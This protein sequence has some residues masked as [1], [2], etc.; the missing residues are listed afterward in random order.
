MAAPDISPSLSSLRAV[1][2]ISASFGSKT[3]H[4]VQQ[5]AGSKE[6]YRSTV[7]GGQKAAHQ[8]FMKAAH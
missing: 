3:A 4:V 1:R 8:T 5:D 6:G 7:S 2:R